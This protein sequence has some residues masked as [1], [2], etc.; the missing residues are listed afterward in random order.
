[1]LPNGDVV[2]GM[3]GE[4]RAVAMVRVVPPL[5]PVV[6]PLLLVVRPLLWP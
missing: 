3:V 1:M 2:G 6:P 4:G 5:L